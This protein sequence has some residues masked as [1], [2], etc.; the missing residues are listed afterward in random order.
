MPSTDALAQTTTQFGPVVVVVHRYDAAPVRFTWG[1]NWSASGWI[2][3]IGW[4]ASPV[5][6]EE[7]CPALANSWT[8]NGCASLITAN[9]APPAGTCP[10]GASDVISGASADMREFGTGAGLDI[11]CASWDVCI[12]GYNTVETC[13]NYLRQDGREGCRNYATHVYYDQLDQ[14]SGTIEATYQRII[15]GFN[16]EYRV[17]GNEGSMTGTIFHDLTSPSGSGAIYVG[18]RY[19]ER[20]CRAIQA[21]GNS[22]NCG[23]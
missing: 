18:F 16:C 21:L 12:Y 2:E 1:Q 10:W 19:S 17:V 15:A 23:L 11:M 14:H 8:E 6:S 22:Y 5:T 9:G 13:N 20:A 7:L 4:F 3:D